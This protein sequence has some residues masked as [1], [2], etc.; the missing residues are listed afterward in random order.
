MKVIISLALGLAGLVVACMAAPAATPTE[1]LNRIEACKNDVLMHFNGMEFNSALKKY[2][3][4]LRELIADQPLVTIQQHQVVSLKAPRECNRFI[5]AIQAAFDSASCMSLDFDE[6][7][8]FMRTIE[9]ESTIDRFLGT[10]RACLMSKNQQMRYD[11]AQD[12]L[13]PTK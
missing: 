2:E 13:V 11:T 7:D 5:S 4:N 12:Q 10:G 8:Q 3:Q 6:F 9:A 1:H